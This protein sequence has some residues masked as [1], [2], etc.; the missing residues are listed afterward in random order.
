LLRSILKVKRLKR[1]QIKRLTLRM[2]RNKQ[3]SCQKHLVLRLI[4]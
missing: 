4:R 1:S 3:L 2:L